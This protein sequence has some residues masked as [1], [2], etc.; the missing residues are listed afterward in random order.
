M[1]RAGEKTARGG[2]SGDSI[3][4]LILPGAVSRDK[5]VQYRLFLPPKSGTNERE[6]TK[7]L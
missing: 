7:K 3:Y 5:N 4:R 2:L 1:Y 6:K